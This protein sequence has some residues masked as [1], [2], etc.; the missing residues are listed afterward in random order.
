MM[1][2]ITICYI[3]LYPYD[4]KTNDSIIFIVGT[5]NDKGKNLVT[6]LVSNKL[7][8]LINIIFRVVSTLHYLIYK[9]E[10]LSVNLKCLMYRF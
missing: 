5:T 8:I 4:E 9:L 6:C 3:I 2:F 10:I 7:L 1:H